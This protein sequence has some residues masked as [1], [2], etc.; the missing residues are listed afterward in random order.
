MF[1]SHYLKRRG[2]FTM[3]ELLVVIAIIG[4]LASIL[5]PAITGGQRSARVAKSKA[6][7]VGY[8]N[9]INKFYEKYNT[10]PDFLAGGEANLNSDSNEFIEAL[11]G[12]T[13]AGV[14]VNNQGNRNAIP[15]LSISESEFNLRADGTT[16][17]DIVDAFENTDI[18][19]RVDID[20]DGRLNVPG[21][22][23]ATGTDREIRARVAIWSVSTDDMRRTART[24]DE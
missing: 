3:I 23:E 18:R 16:G 11:T 14:R 9:A 17:D 21:P 6:Q 13:V 19:I 15:F 10:Y 2:G 5:I 22:G 1:N 24:W 4:I 8:A 7:F 20:G 12:R